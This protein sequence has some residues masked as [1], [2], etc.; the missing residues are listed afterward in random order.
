M[1]ALIA[2]AALAIAA[3]PAAASE[4]APAAPAAGG[5]YVS[6]SP[7]ALPV[8]VSGKVVNYVFVRVRVELSASADS[9]TIRQKEPY[10]RDALVR[11]A[12]RTPFTV[13][14]DYTKIDEAK[15]RAALLRDA[16]ALVGE[17]NVTNIRVMEQ[18]PKTTRVS[19]S[20]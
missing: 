17:R 15:L 4:P 2:L 9:V 19:T 1:R 13:A 14:T 12:H 7:V 11:A 3:T 8:I 6:I 20:R 18:T 10:F 16:R 5:N